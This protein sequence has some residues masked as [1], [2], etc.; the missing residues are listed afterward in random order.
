MK[1]YKD[2]ARDKIKAD[3]LTAAQVETLDYAGTAALCGVKLT[4][5]GDSP[6]DFFYE[7]V[8]RDL[9]REMRDADAKGKRDV[10]RAT[11]QAAIDAKP[12]FAGKT[13]KET[14]DGKLEI[15]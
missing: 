5:K 15:A 14:P 12:E 3:K 2:K 10:L 9:A 6:T 4:T 11:L 13:V 1:K 8:R 7:H